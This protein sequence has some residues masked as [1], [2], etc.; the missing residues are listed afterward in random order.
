MN[1]HRQRP[2]GGNR[3]GVEALPGT[4]A[5]ERVTPGNQ[6]HPSALSDDGRITYAGLP[7]TAGGLVRRASYAYEDA[8]GVVGLIVSR[9]EGNGDKT[10]R[11]G[12]FEGDE[13]VRNGDDV[14]SVPYRLPRVLEAAA[15]GETIFIVEGE[16]DVQAIE[17][18]GHVAT[19]NAGGAENWDPEFASYLVGC[20]RVIVIADKDDAGYRHARVVARSL[21]SVVPYVRIRVAREGKDASDHLA[22]GYALSKLVPFKL[23]KE[24]KPPRRTAP[25]A[26]ARVPALSIQD[27]LELLDGV[28]QVDAGMWRTRCPAHNDRRPSLS[29]GVGDHQPIVL[30]CH[31]G[32]SPEEVA[33]ALDIPLSL[34]CGVNPVGLTT[35]P[36]S[37]VELKQYRWM[38][39]NR[40]AYGKLAIF[41]GD[42]EQGKSLLTLDI[43]ARLSVGAPMPLDDEAQPVGVTLILSAEDDPGDTIA[44]RILAA[45]GDL[46]QV[47]L[48]DAR[49]GPHGYEIP[50][51]L[52]DDVGHLEAA[53][54]ECGASLVII[55]PLAAYLAPRINSNNDASVRQ[56]LG[57]L[58]QVAQATGAAIVLVRHLNKS[59]GDPAIYR[60][61]GSIGIVGIA[62]LGF[63]ISRSP[64]DPAVRVMAASKNNLGLRSDSLLFRVGPNDNELPVI[65]WA[66][67][68]PLTADDLVGR[69]DA[70][71]HAPR[72]EDAEVFLSELLDRRGAVSKGEIDLLA[73]AAGHAFTTVQR[74]AI[75]LDVAKHKV[76][77][78]K[79]QFDQWL[80]YFEPEESDR[81]RIYFDL[82]RGVVLPVRRAG[83][84]NAES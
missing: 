7:E 12:H 32:C 69:G 5:T 71:L 67:T 23:P 22:A 52:P 2:H 77:N 57:P 47:R 34:L 25:K 43:A 66:G 28:Q 44:P 45:G 62:R 18:A 10:F 16:K 78:S 83:E 46:R 72:R 20:P 13:Y 14:P 75:N 55:D 63:T 41:E 17:A 4:K 79:G 81:L 6:A 80:W 48:V 36:L 76:L 26:A 11:Q 74:A 37:D 3:E 31:R 35:T 84:A 29:V 60:G 51:V 59:V 56:A 68:S 40:I 54:R 1:Q 39:R 42:P 65:E 53:I 73:D 15:A 21:A 49:L 70:R 58:R 19:C 33:E 27:L 50:L 82:D 8:D 24:H 61:G 38:W 9:F 30:H 64:T